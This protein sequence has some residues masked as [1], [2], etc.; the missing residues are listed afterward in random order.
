M[1]WN[2]VIIL[3]ILYVIYSLSTIKYQLKLLTKHLNIKDDK[4][5]KVSN[6]EIEKE[7]EDELKR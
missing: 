3:I 5:Q 4:E 2:I 6:E 7:L 1:L